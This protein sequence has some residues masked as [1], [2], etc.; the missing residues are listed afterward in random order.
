M[1]ADQRLRSWLTPHRRALLLCALVLA[2]LFAVAGRAPLPFTKETPGDTADAL[3]SFE[4]HQVVTITGAPVRQTS[5]A[6][7]VTTIL[8]TG[9]GESISLRQAVQGWFDPKAAVLPRDA[10]YPQGNPTKANQQNQQQMT[11]AQDSATTVALN[12]LH[13]S[14]DQVK[15]TIDLGDV[16]GPSGG[17]MLSLAIIDKLAG[18]GKGG[19]L[20][21]G[22]N[23]AGT[24]TIDDSGTI[25]AVGGVALKTQAAA[26]DGATVFLVPRGECSEAK[27]NTPAQLQ[28]IPVNT[29][30]D[31]LSSLNALRGGQPVPSC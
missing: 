28:L 21:G 20:T 26:R 19:D 29:L 7:R 16:G 14:P 4:G 23:I 17:Q 27:V 8:A 11:Q 3:G 18:D 9:P 1:P 13:L 15:V 10:V 25:G 12:Y 24:G 6:L 2:T 22:R 31:A 30:T 5:G